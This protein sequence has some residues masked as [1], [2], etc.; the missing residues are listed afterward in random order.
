MIPFFSILLF[1]FIPLLFF[2][3]RIYLLALTGFALYI[4]IGA[5]SG[6]DPSLT[7]SPYGFW[8]TKQGYTLEVRPQGTYT[9]CD[10]SDCETAKLKVDGHQSVALLNF[11]KLKATHQFI[12]R[13]GVSGSFG[14]ESD[15]IFYPNVHSE[16]Y[17]G[18][19][20]KWVHCDNRPCLIVGNMET[21]EYVFVKQKEY[22]AP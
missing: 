2:Y 18:W 9:F 20:N 11:L 8:T 5:N 14:N 21:K 17:L 1:C 22:A 10:Q 3:T 15:K 12:E 16:E 19:Y 6:G 7:D 4:F 13:S